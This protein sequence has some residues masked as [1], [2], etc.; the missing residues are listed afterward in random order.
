MIEQP[1]LRTLFSLIGILL[2]LPLPVKA[3]PVKLSYSSLSWIMSSVWMAEDEGIFKKHGLDVQLIYIP[4]SSISVQAL[5]SGSVDIITPGSSGVVIAATRGA[6]VVAIAAAT[7]KA[8]FTLY[9]Q[10]EISKPE[11][12]KGKVLG[13]TRFNSTTHMMSVLILRKLGIE[14]KV[15]I[16]QLGDVPAVQSAFDEKLIAGMVTS[17]KPSVEARVLTDA[18]QLDIPYAGSMMTVTRSYLE[19]HRDTVEKVLKAYIEGMAALF[20]QKDR[21]LRVLSKYM[22]RNDSSFLEEMY[23][24]SRKFLEPT[25]TVDPRIVAPI[26]RFAGMRDVNPDQV[27]EKVIDNSIVEQLQR[28]HFIERLFHKKEIKP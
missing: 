24:Y 17:V 15:S 18:V 28:E 1:K 20:S 25:P 23:G 2:F 6:P 21:A 8:P 3:E 11:E 12:L 16:R 7:R 14:D 10:P 26:L 19:Q 4:S 27:A 9:V 5:V 22:R 13:V